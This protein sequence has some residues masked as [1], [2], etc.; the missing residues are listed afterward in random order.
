MST[1]A[2]CVDA[3]FVLRMF[4]GPDDAEAWEQWDAWLREGRSIHAPHLLAYEVV[5]ALCRY[6]RAGYLSLPSVE[7]ALDAALSLPLCLE[8]PRALHLAA[9]R[10]AA[11]LDLA[12]AY[13]AHY[14]AL[15]RQLDAELWT[16]DARLLREAAGAEISIRV[17]GVTS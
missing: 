8:S 14:L 7:L 5:N 15:A 11:G 13:D 17:L 3:S 9:L 10:L 2:V 4:M 6:H 16:A 1:S 12:A